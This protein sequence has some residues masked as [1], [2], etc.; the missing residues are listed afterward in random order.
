MQVEAIVSFKVRGELITPGMVLNIQPE[1][2]PKLANRVKPLTPLIEICPPEAVELFEER[3]GVMEYDGG[4]PRQTA[5]KRAAELICLWCKSTDFWFSIHSKWTCRRCHPPAPG[6]E[7]EG[8][9]T[10][11][12]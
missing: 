6:A 10:V 2:L 1:A 7:D 11:A 12:G 5:E 4:L 8:F 9:K 3:A